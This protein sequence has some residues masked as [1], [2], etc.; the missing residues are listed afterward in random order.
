[1]LFDG[2]IEE[3]GWECFHMILVISFISRINLFLNGPPRFH[4]ILEFLRVPSEDLSVI[5]CIVP[6]VEVV[7]NVVQLNLAVN[8]NINIV[9]FRHKLMLSMIADMEVSRDLIILRSTSY[10]LD[11]KVA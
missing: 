9:E 2:R 1:M 8:V 4:V 5:A 7:D 3:P 6:E 10:F 11:V